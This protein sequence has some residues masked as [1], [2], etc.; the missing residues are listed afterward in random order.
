VEKKP[1]VLDIGGAALLSLSVIALLLGV[2]GLRPVILLPLALGGLV[3]FV[4]VEHRAKEPM[5]PPHL[6]RTRILATSSMLSTVNGAAMIGIIT[7]LP[8]YAQGVLGASPTAAGAAIA[9]M[10]VGWPI[11]GTIAGRLIRP[12]GFR[13]LVRLGMAVIAISALGL[14]V[15]VD[16]G[17]TQLELQIGSAI[18]GVGMGLANTAQVI[19][20]QASVSFRERG[21][22]TASSMFFRNI[23]GTVGVGIMGAFLARALLDNPLARAEG[24]SELVARI[25]GPERKHVAASVLSALSGDLQR[26]VSYVCWI[27]VGLATTALATAWLFPKFESPT[28]DRSQRA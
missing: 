2:E 19:A 9:P 7:F 12:L 13:T 28:A 11:A 25:L 23:G 10:A 3:G 24:G 26:G 16:R 17:A 14:A 1:H 8:L 27:C 15:C 5:L 21:V 18:F 22:A 4:L 20:V 6:F